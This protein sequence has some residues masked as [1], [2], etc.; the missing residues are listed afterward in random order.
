MAKM[1]AKEELAVV[2]SLL[3]GATSDYRAGLLELR[4]VWR[5]LVGKR[6]V[7]SVTRPGLNL[8]ASG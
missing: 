4:K 2:E 7:E 3:K 5:N 8:G 1:A 6:E